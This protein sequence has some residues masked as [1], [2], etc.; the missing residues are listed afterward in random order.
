[1]ELVGPRRPDP[2]TRLVVLVHGLMNTETIWELP[3]GGDYGSYLARD[4]G[5][6]P[7][8]VRYNSGL[9]IAEN[10]V[11]LARLLDDLVR[12]HPVPVE[13]V[14][15]LGYSMGGLVVRAAC[16][17]A[18]LRKSELLRLVR[19]V[20]YVGTPHLG[21]PYERLGRVVSSVLHAVPDPTT[22]LIAD[23]A[24]LRS[25]GLQDLG[26]ADIRHEDRARRPGG[27]RLR[28]WRHPV[29]LLPEIRHHLIAGTLVDAPWMRELFGD[30]VVPVSSA[31]HGTH[32]DGTS[33]AVPERGPHPAA[34]DA[35]RR[36][37]AAV[38]LFPGRSHVAL[39]H[40]PE[41]YAQ[42]RQWVGSKG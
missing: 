34:E 11:A 6:T 37:V 15:L 16:H 18:A 13:E 1:M 36:P 38:R 30:S 28:D 4:E 5:F 10:G 32:A 25:A 27:L 33:P 39:A 3:G 26:D 17:E 29:P 20:I 19:K 7:F 41:V 31:L 9:P 21:A 2:T 8:Y 14:L 23:I 40:D 35:D 42:I 12:A 22:R 24:D